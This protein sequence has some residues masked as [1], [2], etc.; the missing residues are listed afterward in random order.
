MAKG[1]SHHF[2]KPYISQWLLLIVFIM[3]FVLNLALTAHAATSGEAAATDQLEATF[4]IRRFIVYGNTAF[5]RDTLRKLVGDLRGQEQTSA[6]VEKARDRIEKYYHE[7]G[8][9]TT[10][11]NIPEQPIEGGFVYLQ[12]IEGKVGSMT[13]KGNSWLSEKRIRKVLPSMAA[14]EIVSLPQIKKELTAVNAIPDVKMIPALSPGKETGKTDVELTVEDRVPIHGSLELN[15]RSSHDTTP[16]RV[17][18]AL[19]YDDLWGLGH[20]INLQYQGSPQKFSEV[21][22]FSGSYVLPAPW[23]DTHRL[24]MY[25]VYSNSTTTFGESFNTLGKGSII[26]G[27]YIIPFPA[28]SSYN[29]SAVIGFDYKNFV[30]NTFQTG[31]AD[32]AVS[33][34]VTYAPLSLAYNGSLLDSSGVTLFNCGFNMAFRGLVTRQ[35][36]FDNKRFKARANYIYG[37]LGAERRQQLPAGASLLV[38]LDGQIADQPLISNEQYSAG[39]MDSV[40]GYKESEEM[41]DSSFHGVLELAAPNLAPKLGLGERFQ[42]I[43]YTFYDFAALWVKDPLPG[44][45]AAMDIQGTGIGI[46][47]LLFRDL[48]FQTDLAFALSDTNKIKRGDSLVYFKV[49]YQF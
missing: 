42:L 8:Y 45:D 6:D 12:V 23:K 4:P 24:V 1:N 18:A 19:R 7:N 49:K 9:P 26:G 20:S 14:G 37:T 46:R 10:L 3:L 40:R 30:D 36:D 33:S 2:R 5:P 28:Y 41:G 13:V 48:E 34:P 38:K 43:P 35:Q 27:R 32:S 44:Q 31:A 16:L 39:G 21:E 15:N 29:H 25:G 11:V 22:V 47:G 17:N